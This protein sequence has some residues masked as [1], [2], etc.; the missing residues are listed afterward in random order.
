MET[1]EIVLLWV[2]AYIAMAVHYGIKLLSRKDKHKTKFDI[3]YWLKDNYISVFVSSGTVLLLM[4]VFMPKSILVELDKIVLDKFGVII[5]LFYKKVMAM[6]I[7]FL[8]TYLL[9]KIIR[10]LKTKFNE[11]L[12]EK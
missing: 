10:K 2:I 7:G 6:G 11:K 4:L 5:V 12:K 9:D 8:N 1:K 3:I